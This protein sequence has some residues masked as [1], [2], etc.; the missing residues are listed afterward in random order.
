MWWRTRTAATRP[1]CRWRT[2]RAAKPGWSSPTEASRS[3]PST[4]A[5]RACSSRTTTS[6]RAPSGYGAYGSSRPTSLASGRQTATTTTETHGRNSATRETDLAARGARRRRR[7]DTPRQDDRLRRTRLARPPRRPARR[8][9]VDGRGRL[10]SRAKL[11]DRVGAR[12]HPRRA[13]R[14]EARGR[15]GLPLPDRRAPAGRQD[16]ATRP[17][18]RLLRLG[19]FRGRPAHA[20]GRRIGHR[21]ADGDDPDARS[22][23]RPHG[24]AVA[25]L[26]TQPGRHHLSRR[27]RAADRQRPHRRARAHRFTTSRVDELRA[28]CRRRDASRGFAFAGR[29]AAFLRVRTDAVRRGGGRIARPA[30]TRHA[31]DQDRTLWTHRTVTW[32]S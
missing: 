11:L 8:C 23:R 3:S 30:R 2:S 20:R 26:F 31:G 12:R 18:R 4:A 21:A 16:R 7:R 1:T 9:P 28:P 32:A 19:T 29:A 14:P 17:D 13:H 15:R 22:R 25:L 6:G 10:S 24:D 27:A 5:P